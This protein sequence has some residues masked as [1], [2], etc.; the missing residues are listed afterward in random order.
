MRLTPMISAIL[1]DG[2]GDGTPDRLGDTLA[3][4]GRVTAAPAQLSHVRSNVATLQDDTDGIH[5]RLPDGPLVSRGDS[6]IVRG[7]LLQER[8]LTAIDV[9][10]YRIVPSPPRTPKPVPLTVATTVEDHYEGWLARTRGRVVDRRRTSKGRSLV[11]ESPDGSSSARLSLFVADRH[12]NRFRLDRFETGDVVEATGIV[13]QHGNRYLIEPR[14]DG[15][16]VQSALAWEYLRIALIIL[17]GLATGAVIWGVVLQG[18]VDRRTRQLKEAKRESERMRKL[19]ESVFESAPV[20]IMLLDEDNRFERINKQFETVLGWTEEELLARDDAWTLLYPDDTDR[21]ETLAFVDGAPT[22]RLESRPKTRDG[23]RLITEWWRTDLEEGRRLCLGVDITDRKR[24]ERDLRRAKQHAETARREAEEASR[25]K[26]V[27]LANMSHEI[28][29]PLTSII[30][31]AE[32]IGD[33]AEDAAGENVV[34]FARLIQNSGHRLLNTLNA[35]LNLSKLE[36]GEMDLSLEPVDLTQEA[37]SS[38]RQ[39]LQ[40]AD[41]RGIDLRVDTPDRPVFSQA[42]GGAIQII[43]RNLISNAIKYSAKG[44]RVW[45]RAYEDDTGAAVL[46]VEDEGMGMDPSEVEDLFE[47]FRQASEGRDRTHEGTG[48]G[49]AVT[50]KAADAMKGTVTVET[51]Q[52]VGS[53]FSVQLPRAEGVKPQRTTRP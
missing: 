10:Q 45:V 6:L 22:D 8:G 4:S 12:E 31:F 46:E 38:A 20:M 40:K 15:D 1:A 30:G 44:S 27:F 48:I 35:V 29:T 5:A 3:V 43:L 18:A 52:G 36:T 28:R 33:E 50:K 14:D 24:Q 13:S 25:L 11:L 17:G 49:L 51:E 21:R 7:R 26:S 41:E 39:L 47:A 53:R 42:D 34:R 2:N 32:T 23:H 37:R 19:F 9:T 16:L